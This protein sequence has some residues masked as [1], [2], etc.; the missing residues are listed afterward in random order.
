LPAALPTGAFELEAIVS[1]CFA[2]QDHHKLIEVAVRCLGGFPVF[3]SER[4]YRKLQNRIFPS[5]P[6]VG[7]SVAGLGGAL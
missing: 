6:S 5:A 1:T 4:A 7:R 3:S 2:V